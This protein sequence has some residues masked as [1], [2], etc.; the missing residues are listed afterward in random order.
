MVREG[1][2]VHGLREYLARRGAELALLEPALVS[3]GDRVNDEINGSPVS[4]ELGEHSIKIGIAASIHR[5]EPWVSEAKFG[6]GI[7]AAAFHLLAGQVRECALRA[8]LEKALS[9]E[10]CVAAIVGDA[11]DETLLALHQSCCIHGA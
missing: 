8:G 1:T 3:K 4:L 9:D 5:H 7:A 11:D 2:D 6:E 10:C